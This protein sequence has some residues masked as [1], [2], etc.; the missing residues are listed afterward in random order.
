MS[1][2]SRSRLLIAGSCADLHSNRRVSVNISAVSVT[3]WAAL[4]QTDQ[5][6]IIPNM[7]ILICGCQYSS[8][9]EHR[10]W[11]WEVEQ[12]TSIMTHWEFVYFKEADELL[13]SKRL[14]FTWQTY[15]VPNNLGQWW[16]NFFLIFLLLIC[17]FVLEQ[18]FQIKSLTVC[19]YIHVK[20]TN[21]AVWY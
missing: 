9:T 8:V 13:L 4:N 3:L 6:H 17:N 14:M 19:F 12:C 2:F 18:C 15:K 10:Y 20:L 5:R 21:S 16:R 7:M 1:K 11:C